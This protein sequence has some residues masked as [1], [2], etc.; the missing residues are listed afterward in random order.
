MKQPAE[1]GVPAKVIGRLG[2]FVNQELYGRPTE[3]PWGLQVDD[4]PPG[5]IVRIQVEKLTGVGP[6]ST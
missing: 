2:N 4:P 1:I 5:S 3:L 6:W